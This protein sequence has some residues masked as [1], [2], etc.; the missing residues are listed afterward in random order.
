[1]ARDL[2]N[3]RGLVYSPTNEQGVVFLFGKVAEDLNMYVEEIKT[4]FPDCIGRRFTGRGWELVAIEFE[5]KSSN[6]ESHGHSPED[7]DVIVCWEHDWPGAP[8]EVIELREVIRDLPNE[9]IKRPDMSVD[10]ITGMT[11]TLDAYFVRRGTNKRAQNLYRQM[12]ERV[13]SIDDEIWVKISEKTITFYSPERVFAYVSGQKTQIR[14][15]LFTRGQPMEEVSTFGMKRGGHKW[16]RIVLRKDQ[17]LEKVSLALEEAYDRIR[18]AIRNNEN[19]G[20]Y[21]ELEGD[22]E[23]ELEEGVGEA[24]AE[25]ER[26][27]GAA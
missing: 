7:C 15:T 11:D 10:V 24:D 19:T 18:E 9:P 4:G 20:W 16:G 6:F 22:E 2:I 8:M 17:D 27:A 26:D 13:R 23:D 12:E 21:A 25:L 1:M 14:L 5:F 3:F